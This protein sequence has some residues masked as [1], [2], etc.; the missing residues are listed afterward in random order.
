MAPTLTEIPNR[1]D[2]PKPI[3][4]IMYYISARDYCC[5]M[6]GDAVKNL[7]T[8]EPM[9]DIDL[10]TNAEID[11]LELVLE[12]YRIIEFHPEK[13][14]MMVMAGA[15]PVMI[16]SFRCEDEE[17]P[18]PNRTLADELKMRDF[19][20]FT[21]CADM[22]GNLIDPFDGISCL[23]AEP[24]LLKAV[25][26]EI[27]PIINDEGE[28]IPV[29]LSV[30]K[31]PLC[32]LQALILMGDGEYVI[33]DKTSK[34]IN[35]NAKSILQLDIDR[36]R[37]KFEQILM[38]KR[39]SDVFLAFDRVVITLF[40][41]LADT[42]DFDQHSI[43]HSYKLYEHLSKSV[44]FSVP[45]LALRYALLFHGAGKPDCQ[46]INSDGYATY[47]GHSER[48]VIFV[49]RALERLNV[50]KDIIDEICFLIYNHDIGEVIN[51]QNIQE[52]TER[53]SKPEVR[54]LLLFASSNIRAKNP[55]NEPKAANLKKLAETLPK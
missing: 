32:L 14:E 46:A 28:P 12:N 21:I 31:D 50:N 38:A 8:G 9:G 30:E 24:Y 35:I 23:M 11:R 40:P 55:D 33:S 17:I 51:E 4:S 41:E 7:L 3:A 13:G 52:M 48:S 49:K 15:I 45:D 20:V 36:L 54:K 42:V 5:Y 39:V 19:T 22:D 43:F 25:G 16:S 37:V 44:G 6:V 34:A 53:F 2:I 18:I 29:P 10:I 26:E 1:I 47:F 27:A